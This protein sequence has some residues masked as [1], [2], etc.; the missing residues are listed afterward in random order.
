VGFSWDFLGDGRTAL[1]GGYGLYYNT[2][3]SST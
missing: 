3:A 1:R 2:T